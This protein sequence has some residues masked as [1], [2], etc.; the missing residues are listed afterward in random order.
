MHSSA[1][2][3]M[4]PR[5]SC[6]PGKCSATP[7]AALVPFG[8]LVR[9]LSLTHGQRPVSHLGCGFVVGSSS[10]SYTKV[11]FSLLMPCEVKATIKVK[12]LGRETARRKHALHSCRVCPGPQHTPFFFFLEKVSGWQDGRLAGKVTPLHSPPNLMT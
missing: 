12:A 9:P 4:G 8:G 10:Y 5:A 1:V 7:A 2:L 3:G 6:T 11:K